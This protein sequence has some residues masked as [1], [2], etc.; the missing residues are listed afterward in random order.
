MGTR[1][2]ILTRGFLLLHCALFS[3]GCGINYIGQRFFIIV[4]G[5]DQLALG[6]RASDSHCRYIFG[7][8]KCTGGSA[9]QWCHACP[10]NP[11]KALGPSVIHSVPGV[12]WR[13]PKPARFP[14]PPTY[15]VHTYQQRTSDQ[16][17]T[18]KLSQCKR[19]LCLRRTVQLFFAISYHF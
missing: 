19:L 3:S 15:V 5:T 18:A 7:D 1:L 9:R 12:Q 14:H 10:I 8:P 6:I 4:A 2:T 16:R 17:W 11:K 13:D